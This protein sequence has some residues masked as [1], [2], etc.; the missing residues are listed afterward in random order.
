MR[1]RG[2]Y[3]RLVTIQVV[4]HP[5]ARLDVGDSRGRYIHHTGNQVYF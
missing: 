2:V 3:N 5:S 4:V 1:K